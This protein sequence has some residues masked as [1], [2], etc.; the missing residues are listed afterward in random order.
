VSEGSTGRSRPPS[1]KGKP[2]QEAK[3]ETREA[4]VT[5][6]MSLFSEEGVDVPSLDAI[7]ARAGFTRG[8]FYVHFKDR[9]DFLEAVLE[10]VLTDFVTSLLAVS[11]TANDVH[12]I[13]D[14]FLDAAARGKVPLMGQRRLIMQLTAQG[15]ERAERVQARFRALLSTVIEQLAAAAT[16]G[17]QAGTIGTPVAP[18]LIGLWL[19]AGALGITVI[20]D[21]GVPVPFDRIPAS[22]QEL[23]QI[24]PP[25]SNE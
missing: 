24:K 6:G 10:R 25:G 18:D 12:L 5:A 15:T 20:A 16:R 8:A 21:L 19:A 7:C 3:R 13:I 23:F 2:R 4:L 1:G 11:D 9:D 22:A 14:R 17:Q